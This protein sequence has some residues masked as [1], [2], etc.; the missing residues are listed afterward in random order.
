VAAGAHLCGAASAG[1]PTGG[2][3]LQRRCGTPV[4][5]AG[6]RRGPPGGAPAAWIGLHGL[7]LAP[8]R[9]P[10][11]FR[12]PRRHHPGPGGLPALV[13]AGFGLGFWH[14]PGPGGLPAL[15]VSGF[16]LRFW[17]LRGACG[18]SVPASTFRLGFWLR[19]GPGG[20]P[21]LVASGFRLGFCLRHRAGGVSVPTSGFRIGFWQS[22]GAGGLP[23]PG[24]GF[25]V[26]FC[27]RLFLCQ[28]GPGFWQHHRPF[29]G[30]G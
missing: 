27:F 3:R 6:G 4:Q 1:G 15:E 28:V 14:H 26:R 7:R 23:T 16:P 21:V 17:L 2:V 9:P 8:L 25:W 24:L 11:G 13:A 19:C 20:L 5:P 22:H 12:L 10:A 18:V 29:L 30:R